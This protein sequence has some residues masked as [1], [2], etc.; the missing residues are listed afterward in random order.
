MHP[1]PE[2]EALHAEVARLRDEL[3]H[4]ATALDAG[5]LL[6][7]LVAKDDITERKRRTRAYDQ[8]PSGIY[9][10]LEDIGRIEAAMDALK[11]LWHKDDTNYRKAMMHLSKI[12]WDLRE[13]M[14]DYQ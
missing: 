6:R 5:Q 1:D 8:L 7:D 9:E 2:K 13:K 3:S 12:A 4:A 11:R 14:L 10:T